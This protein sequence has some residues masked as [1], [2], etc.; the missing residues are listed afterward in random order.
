MIDIDQAGGISLERVFLTPRRDLR[1]IT[2]YFADILANPPQELGREDYL[3][4]T[5]KDT[6]PI[7]DAISRLREV[8]PNILHI[9]RP[10]LQSRGQILELEGDHRQTGDLDLFSSFFA[11]VTGNAM[12]EDEARVLAV[13]VAPYLREDK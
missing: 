12:T 9:E 7:L 13:A 11:Q 5:L 6:G 4:V 10:A 8:Y 3:M 1:A 2:G